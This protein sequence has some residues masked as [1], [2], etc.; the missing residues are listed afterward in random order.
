MRRDDAPMVIFKRWEGFGVTYPTYGYFY[1]V[2][3]DELEE[4]VKIEVTYYE[5]R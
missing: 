4:P 5:P 2:Y 3:D 1:E